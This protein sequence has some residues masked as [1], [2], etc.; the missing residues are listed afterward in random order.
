MGKLD[1]FKDVSFDLRPHVDRIMQA[2]EQRR[3]SGRP[4]YIV[5]G[6]VHDCPVEKTIVQFL[7]KRLK[8]GGLSVAFCDE[9]TYKGQLGLMAGLKKYRR[10]MGFDF[11]DRFNNI[12]H[13]GQET[14]RATLSYPPT[15]LHSAAVTRLHLYD[16]CVKKEVSF[17]SVDVLKRN[18]Y[19]IDLND[20][21]TK[22]PDIKPLIEAE[23]IASISTNGM[24]IRNILMEERLRKHAESHDICVFL[25][26]TNHVAGAKK[27]SYYTLPE[28]TYHNSIME[29][30]LRN[31]CNAL[32][33]LPF[34]HGFDN[35]YMHPETQALI[36]KED[37]ISIYGLPRDTFRRDLDDETNTLVNIIAETGFLRRLYQA[38][39]NEFQILDIEKLN[40]ENEAYVQANLD[41]WIRAAG[42]TP[43]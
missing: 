36:N 28:H 26:G 24:A 38:S 2:V 35:S 25:T 19:C 6:E 29:L 30:L 13:N 42:L 34:Q 22:R 20:I 27:G 31:E 32:G 17:Y 5:V 18:D 23:N 37:I 7:L 43:S 41:G 16:L 21:D 3:I 4:L 10:A 39:G 15:K 33:V 1:A 14:L 40:A 8:D 11:T 9:D 12:D